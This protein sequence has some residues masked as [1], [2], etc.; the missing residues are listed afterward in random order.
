MKTRLRW[1]RFEMVGMM[2]C[3]LLCLI[4]SACDRPSGTV[5]PSAKH[6]IF[7]SLDT[8]R[9][10]H[11]GLYG[12]ETVKTP[13]LDRLASESIVLDDFMTV[14]PTTLASHVSLFTGKYPH[15]HGI[16]R[17][18]FVVHEDNVMLAELLRER[19]FATAGFAGSF[20]LESRFNFTQGFEHYD[21]TF[22]RM[23]GE[24]GLEQSER[25]AEAVTRAVVDYLDR[26]GV[27]DHL[28]LFVHYF[29]PHEPYEAPPPYDTIYDSRG[30][31]GLP[32]WADASREV[33]LRAG[34]RTEL[35]E[36]MAAQYAAEITYMDHHIGVLLEELR[37]RGIFDDALLVVTSDHGENHWEHAVSFDHGWTTYDS[38]MRAVG[39]FRL[40]GAEGGG[41]RIDALTANID[42][43]PTVLAYLGIS[44]PAGIDGDAVDLT[45]P[46]AATRERIRF[47]QATK[48]WE[49]VEKDPRWTNMLKARCIRQG[50]YKLIQVPFLKREE[51]YDLERDPL[52]QS[53]LLSDGSP[54]AE[55]V[56][57]PLRER[58]EAWAVSANPLPS[59]FDPS[60]R[61]ET[62]ERLKSLGYLGG[63]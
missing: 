60:Q 21:E 24:H 39:I 3:S 40:P 54:E 18:G 48:P 46:P 50:N 59:R 37:E 31:E 29:D 32:Y 7:I 62:I 4:V 56:A 38:T 58:L 22:Q 2:A 43:F 35:A 55:V 42:I 41:A 63:G 15:T 52:E 13:N 36:R 45:D 16:P 28:F 20:A 53:D 8:T 5:D 27:A 51:L 26:E 6:V 57:R 23:A 30:R 17:N 1:V 12:N 11:F 44:S 19:G 25:S 34:Q 10:D 47:G 9:A 33:T 61:Q 49:E 14:V